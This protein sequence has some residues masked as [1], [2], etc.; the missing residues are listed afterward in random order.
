MPTVIAVLVV[1]MTMLVT[2][3]AAFVRGL[4]TSAADTPGSSGR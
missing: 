4:M 1:L 2:R 3:Q